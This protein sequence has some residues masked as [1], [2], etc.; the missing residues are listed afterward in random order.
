MKAEA[1]WRRCFWSRGSAATPLRKRLMKAKEREEDE[2]ESTLFCVA[3]RN[4]SILSTEMYT[5]FM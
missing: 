3:L 2:D 1:G 4:T 5:C